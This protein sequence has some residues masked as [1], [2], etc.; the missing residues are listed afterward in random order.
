MAD[1]GTKGR[2]C[3][4]CEHGY[5]GAR[6]LYCESFGEFIADEKVA[7]ECVAFDAIPA[8]VI[9][10]WDKRP[11]LA[12][13]GYTPD[14][15]GVTF[16]SITLSSNTSTSTQVQIS[17]SHHPTSTWVGGA[18][19]DSIRSALAQVEEPGPTTELVALCDAF[20]QTRHCTLYGEVFEIISPKGRAQAANW[21]AEQI[22]AITQAKAKA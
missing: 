8:N 19:N 7:E 10:E 11:D 14:Q 16:P 2:V 21:L 5:G 20:L 6:G 18:R 15:S 13:V 3:S 12:V 1:N 4:D 22:T 9:T 17:K